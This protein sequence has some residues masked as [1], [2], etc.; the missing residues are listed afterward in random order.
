MKL[1]MSTLAL[2]GILISGQIAEANQSF[3]YDCHEKNC[4]VCPCKMDESYLIT[5]NKSNFTLLPTKLKFSTGYVTFKTVSK[6][7]GAIRAP[8]LY[9]KFLIK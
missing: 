5:S 3:D 1:L 6:M 2:Y 8:P 9:R 4:F 7:F